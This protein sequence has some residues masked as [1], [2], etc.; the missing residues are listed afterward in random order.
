MQIAVFLE[1]D[2]DHAPKYMDAF[3][4]RCRQAVK[5][6]AWTT[7]EEIKEQF[8]EIPDKNCRKKKR[9]IT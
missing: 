9:E 2:K 5:E 1:I 7:D 6:Q 4:T 8:L 3:E